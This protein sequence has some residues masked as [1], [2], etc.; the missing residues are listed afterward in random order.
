MT[1]HLYP[2]DQPH[3]EP[4][5]TADQT[6]LSTAVGGGTT[7]EAV[8][9]LAAGTLAI[10]GLAGVLPFYMTTI[11]IIAA[12]AALFIE[13]ATV[14]GAYAKLSYDATIP[15]AQQLEVGGGFGAQGIGG[16]AAVVL[17]ILS[18]VG[19]LPQILVPISAMV[20]GAALLLGGAAR[21]E[22]NFAQLGVRG[23]SPHARYL[24]HQAIIG[25]S[26]VLALVGIGA[27]VL[28]ILALVQGPTFE[29]SLIAILAVGAAELFGGSAMLGRLVVAR[30]H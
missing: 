4:T 16:A 18:L 9:G 15:E 28:G 27:L 25:T 7:A 8:A 14:A 5:P 12:G 2:S 13:G 6:K 26:G 17:G 22:L 3:L 20:L 23:G 29:L 24:A 11:G 1:S 19:I 30:R 21:P 10:L